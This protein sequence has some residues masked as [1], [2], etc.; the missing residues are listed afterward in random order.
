MEP[1]SPE[2]FDFTGDPSLRARTAFD[3]EDEPQ[4]PP[5][6]L[7]PK[8]RDVNPPNVQVA[9]RPHGSHSGIK[10]K[11]NHPEEQHPNIFHVKDKVSDLMTFCIWWR[12]TEDE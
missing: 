8:Q 1:Y 12:H 9:R 2:A 4:I 7:P 10:S 5:P 6:S 11:V 3:F